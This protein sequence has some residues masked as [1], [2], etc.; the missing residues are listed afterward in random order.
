MTTRFSCS[1]LR[2][3]YQVPPVSAFMISPGPVAWDG[4][5][6]QIRCGHCFPH[7][8]SAL[9]GRAVAAV[10]MAVAHA[11]THHH[12]LAELKHF[13]RSLEFMDP[14]DRYFRYRLP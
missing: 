3:Q 10:R 9:A 5:W 1:G 6:R 8:Q 7:G 13:G 14:P 11:I 4:P 2:T 12:L